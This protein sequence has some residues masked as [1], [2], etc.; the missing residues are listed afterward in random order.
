M[1]NRCLDTYLTCLTGTRP[2]QWP[3]WLSWAEFWFN[4]NYN[5]SPRLTPFKA[6]YGRDPPHLLKGAT[7]SSVVEEVNLMTHE[8]DQL[9]HN[10][11]G[12]LVK[13]QNQMKKYADQSRCP[14]SLFVG[15]W[16]YLKL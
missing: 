11:K 14:I 1:V 6:L 2:K 9:L 12:N 3:E 7:I 10:L 16:V 15:D 8:W 4:T 13:A 5:S